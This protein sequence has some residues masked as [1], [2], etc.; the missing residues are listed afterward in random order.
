M[1]GITLSRTFTF[2][3]PP[4]SSA[5]LRAVLVWT[6]S[7]CHQG[8]QSTEG[9]VKQ[10]EASPQRK[11]RRPSE[12]VRE[13]RESC[14]ERV[15][16]LVTM[17]AILKTA[18][19]KPHFGGHSAHFPSSHSDAYGKFTSSKITAGEFPRNDEDYGGLSPGTLIS[20]AVMIEPDESGVEKVHSGG[21]RRIT[22]PAGR[23]L[24]FLT[25]RQPCGWP[26]SHGSP[27]TLGVHY[28]SHGAKPSF[29]HLLPAA[30]K[31]VQP[32]LGFTDTAGEAL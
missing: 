2:D 6:T 26:P 18:P 9:G 17:Q 23:S 20:R 22:V 16:T 8:L 3:G 21:P 29:P 25:P 14:S 7:G 30:V 28:L 19:N 4:E 27:R 15:F 11:L 1:S 32:L 24:A 5:P 12:V 13:L 31:C 10:R